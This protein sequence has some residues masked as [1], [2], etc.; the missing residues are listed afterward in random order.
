M[1]DGIKASIYYK[2]RE[3]IQRKV[4]VDEGGEGRAV[5]DEIKQR[6]LH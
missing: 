2:W 5:F 3:G 6:S 4:E 1:S